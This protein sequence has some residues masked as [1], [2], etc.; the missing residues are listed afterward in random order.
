MRNRLALLV[1]LALLVLGVAWWFARSSVPAPGPVEPRG[2]VAT[3]T[4]PAPAAE[5]SA[6]DTREPAV[7]EEASAE[8]ALSATR[9]ARRVR[10]VDALSGS[11]DPSAEAWWLPSKDAYLVFDR[12]RLEEGLDD[13]SAWRRFGRALA[14]D[15][16]AEVTLPLEHDGAARVAAHS[17]RGF[18]EANLEADASGVLE[19]RLVREVSIDVRVV[20]GAARP[21][22]D[23]PVALAD[24][25]PTGRREIPQTTD[26]NGR[27]HLR[28]IGAWLQVGGGAYV[29]GVALPCVPLVA[30]E[31]D[32]AHLPESEVTLVLPPTASVHVSCRVIDVVEATVDRVQVRPRVKVRPNLLA[33]LD[34]PY[35]GLPL[36][37]GA[38]WELD[39]PLL[40]AG[41][42]LLFEAE[43]REHGP[44]RREVEPLAPG[45]VRRLEIVFDAPQ[46]IVVAR[47]VHEDGSPYANTAIEVVVRDRARNMIGGGQRRT[48]TD[49]DGLVRLPQ[50]ELDLGARRELEFK[51]SAESFAAQV[52]LPAT[53]PKLLDLG[54]VVLCLPPLSAAG[55]VVDTAGIPIRDATV[56]LRVRLGPTGWTNLDGAV[57]RTD[58]AGHF[59]LRS[60]CDDA[61]IQ[62]SAEAEGWHDFRYPAIPTLRPGVTDAL[63]VLEAYGGLS[64]R[65]LVPPGMAADAC[66]IYWLRE[67]GPTMRYLASP[68]PD[69]R[70]AAQVLPT[71]PGQLT[72]DLGPANLVTIA[73]LGIVA[74][75]TLQDPSFNPL[76]LSAAFDCVRF[77]VVNGQGEPLS[78]QLRA[79]APA[80]DD[81]AARTWSMRFDASGA[82]C[83]RVAG[84]E[85]VWV[86]SNGYQHAVVELARALDKVVLEDGFRVVFQCPEFAAPKGAKLSLQPHRGA[87]YS[88]PLV[89]TPGGRIEWR[90]PLVGEWELD[91]LLFIPG[92]GY[93]SQEPLNVQPA[94]I[95]VTADQPARH[96]LSFDADELAAVLEKYRR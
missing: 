38:E 15:A 41:V 88:T 70:F 32:A 28:D 77:A 71:G 58:A 8:P 79:V 16:Q 86:T 30:L 23:V 45:E 96:L 95:T 90:A 13:A 27:A 14:L 6:S 72:V 29:V 18:A 36:P 34:A 76:D 74:G 35:T 25:T 54:D 51:L 5:V 24:R 4:E 40:P 60:S 50:G 68:A 39:F 93:P 57:A 78:G 42:P 7:R 47:L 9:V 31:F 84:L 67:Q 73:D 83:P 10:V 55:R 61:E 19:L 81:W 12:V 44:E 2:V 22:G 82:V 94:R 52:E 56:R 91:G 48:K 21:V 85:R 37:H 87:T 59:E 33:L 17:P 65:L 53:L 20:D 62:L 63:I 3:S 26:A 80:D 46:P 75:E 92:K 1:G 66:A 89:T 49:A 11:A 43:L 69:G 64:G